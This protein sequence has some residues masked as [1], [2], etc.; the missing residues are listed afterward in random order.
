MI[1][2]IDDID[3]QMLDD[4][5]GVTLATFTAWV[6]ETRTDKEQEIQLYFTYR[7]DCEKSEVSQTMGEDVAIILPTVKVNV[8][9]PTKLVGDDSMDGGGEP[10]HHRLEEKSRAETEP[11][12]HAG[13]GG[14]A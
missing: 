6:M 14:F 12:V 5:G 2:S 8:R 1:P 7:R 13:A 3:M 9:R 11:M 10:N 4:E